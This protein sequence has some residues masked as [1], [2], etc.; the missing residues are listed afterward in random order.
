VAEAKVAGRSEA[1]G[2]EKHRNA[3]TRVVC[4]GPSGVVPMI[5]CETKKI[6]GPE[7][8]DE[9][10]KAR[11]EFLEGEAIARSIAAVAE[12]GVEI[13]EVCHHKP[14]ITASVDRSEGF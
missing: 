12:D 10:R 9:I 14:S 13:H 6:G 8:C 2:V 5:C 1:C 4:A 7:F 3:L 11:V